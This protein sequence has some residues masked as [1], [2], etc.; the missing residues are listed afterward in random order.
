MAT[1]QEGAVKRP[2]FA[3][4]VDACFDI[5]RY[6]SDRGKEE[7][8]LA[9]LNL[10]I[11]DRRFGV[12][13]TRTRHL[14]T[15]SEGVRW[16]TLQGRMHCCSLLSSLASLGDH[17]P[18]FCDVEGLLD[19]IVALGQFGEEH[20]GASAA[21]EVAGLVLSNLAVDP[22]NALKILNTQGA[23][24][25]LAACLVGGCTLEGTTAAK[26]LS[27]LPLSQAPSERGSIAHTRAQ[28]FIEST[29]A[30]RELLEVKGAGEGLVQILLEG[31]PQSKIEA[32]SVLAKL[33]GE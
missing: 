23:V 18:G 10:S 16:G 28:W 3:E 6:A 29:E 13:L 8:A 1:M 33:T 32:A 5:L 12:S 11:S 25:M 27:Y 21:R 15:I 22:A 24:R 4:A 7:A 17:G 14:A 9:L 2:D 30:T 26:A 19:G 31:Q 20:E